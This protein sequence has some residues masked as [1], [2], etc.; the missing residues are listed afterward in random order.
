MSERAPTQTTD[1]ASAF[2]PEL[3][4]AQ[5]DWSDYL[6]SRD[7]QDANGSIHSAQNGRFKSNPN[8]MDESAYFNSQLDS[9][10]TDAE[11]QYGLAGK[12]LKELAEA[13]RDAKARGDRTAEVDAREIFDD[14]FIAMAEKYGWEGTVEYKDGTTDDRSRIANDR[15][16]YYESIMNGGEEERGNERNENDPIA[17][18]QQIIDQ[19]ADLRSRSST[20]TPDEQ[21]TLAAAEKVLAGIVNGDEQIGSAKGKVK[22]YEDRID[23][24]KALIDAIVKKQGVSREKATEIFAENWD[25]D[26]VQGPAIDSAEQLD[27]KF[28]AAWGKAANNPAFA[29]MPR[30]EQEQAFKTFSEG[31]RTPS[32]QP[33]G[34]PE[35][36]G[37]TPDTSAESDITTPENKKEKDAHLKATL[38]AY[39]N[40]AEL[41]EAMDSYAETVAQKRRNGLSSWMSRG[42]VGKLLSKITK[43][44]IV[45]NQTMA[46]KSETYKGVANAK[47]QEIIKA[48]DAE[49]AQLEKDILAK[50]Q[51]IANLI[52]NGASEQDIARAKAEISGM[53]DALNERKHT[54][55]HFMLDA[56][57]AE[58][59]TLESSIASISEEKAGKP[60]KIAQWFVNGGKLKKTA[61][62]AAG[63]AL[64]VGSAVLFPPLGIPT[65]LAGIGAGSAAAGAGSIMNRNAAGVVR[66]DG[67]THAQQ[68]KVAGLGLH[69]S[70]HRSGE[71]TSDNIVGN[72]STVTAET[73]KENR[74]RVI[75]AAGMTALGATAGNAAYNI[76][77]GMFAGA[78][79]DAQPPAADAQPPAAEP[80]PNDGVLP[81]DPLRGYTDVA[82][83]GDL[84]SPEVVVGSGDGYINA[85][86]SLGIDNPQEVY[87][88]LVK[89]LGAE[90]IFQGKDAY[91]INNS[92]GGNYG[93]DAPGTYEFTQKALEWM[94]NHGI[95]VK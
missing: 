73:N 79:P 71:M 21:R 60:G 27:P 67:I 49:I 30:A 28:W 46:E 81:S 11:K 32:Q 53:V 13:I 93:I 16:A 2:D 25:S 35:N 33:D 20:L 75:R 8:K 14:K 65:V 3:R 1:V 34:S 5:Q 58:A 68:R 61:F 7:V 39:S 87:Q 37:A 76:A 17:I 83:G 95:S 50:R 89:D 6:G 26:S 62:F 74:R 91:F 12:K 9:S 72:I 42:V 29:K 47:K 51:E 31:W 52:G 86:D 23:H 82:S 54:R 66:A 77:S 40:D 80:H 41:N 70:V 38:E 84:V 22:P 45:S 43:G 56:T 55:E 44:K 88:G 59:C 85:L 94:S 64:G 24:E 78:A 48:I 57:L 10:A 18:T 4:Q 69:D 92:I 36:D 63:A 90:G 19:V 15:L